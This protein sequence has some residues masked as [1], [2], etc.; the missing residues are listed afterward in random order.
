MFNDYSDDSPHPGIGSEDTTALW[1][2][3]LYRC[4]ASRATPVIVSPTGVRSAASIWAGARE[5]TR[6][7]REARIG[8]GTR[9]HCAHA[10]PMV[11]LQLLVACLWDGVDLSL[12]S[13]AVASDGPDESDVFIGAIT[14]PD[15][16]ARW[17]VPLPGGW[18]DPDAPLGNAGTQDRRVGASPTQAPAVRCRDDAVVTHARLLEH[19][20]AVSRE[21]ELSGGR[22]LSLGGWHTRAGLTAGLVAP[23]LH[24]E[25][26]FIADD[27]STIVSLLNDEPLTHVVDTVGMSDAHVL[28]W[29]RA[30]PERADQVRVC[31][32]PSWRGG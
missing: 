11:L 23:L 2:D 31:L 25:E 8:V 27:P 30:H 12:S 3:R 5:W 22:V 19:A 17:H 14:N 21:L 26:L 1:R 7:L 9:V 16:S 6:R 18:P 10:D 15:G 29:M 4:L 32:I 28:P 20:D 13:T 24:A